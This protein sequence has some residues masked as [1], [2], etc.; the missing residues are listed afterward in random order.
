MN[1]IRFEH[2]VDNGFYAVVKRRV[3][4]YFRR[5]EKSRFANRSV[6]L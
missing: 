6:L 5:T 2:E 1:A 4:D 3:G